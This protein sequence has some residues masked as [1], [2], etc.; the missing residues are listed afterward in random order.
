MC[1]PSI[2]PAIQTTI[3]FFFKSVRNNSQQSIEVT[4]LSTSN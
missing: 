3:L 2:C 1:S 4:S